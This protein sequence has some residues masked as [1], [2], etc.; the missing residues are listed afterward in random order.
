MEEHGL[1]ASVRRG[2][3]SPQYR[4]YGPRAITGYGAAIW[5]TVGWDDRCGNGVN[6]FGIT[7]RV[8]A[9]KPHG[10]RGRWD[11]DVAGG[12]MHDEIA[13]AFPELAPFIKWHLTMADGPM[14][15]MGNVRF[16]AGIRDCWGCRKGEPR[17]WDDCVRFGKN[18][19]AH[20]LKKS[21]AHFICEH[22]PKFDFEVIGIAHE[23]R[24]GETYKFGSKYT[25]GGYGNQWHECP[26][27]SEAEAL[28]F[29][30]ALQDC[31]PV[32]D[33]IPTLWG[34][35]KERQLDFARSGAVWPD[36]SDADLIALADGP[37]EEFERV[38][39]ARLPALMQE[40]K[41]AVESLG[42]TY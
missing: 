5:A 13:K 14:H 6:S 7:A 40:F 23:D 22:A 3:D 42:F 18:P 25:F 26:F 19:I 37:K 41:Q 33:K 1:P 20:P 11:S 38:M 39:L 34:E 4:H 10:H 9:P 24:P 21:F 27:D 29:L 2:K 15:Y 17:A 16:H 12:C 36:I 8:T 35:G 31:E 32:F 28:A 30:H